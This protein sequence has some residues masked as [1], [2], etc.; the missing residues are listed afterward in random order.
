M[1][2]NSKTLQKLLISTLCAL[3][4]LI[5]LGLLSVPLSDYMPNVNSFFGII[6][7]FLPLSSLIIFAS[8]EILNRMKELS[9]MKDFFLSKKGFYRVLSIFV[10]LFIVSFS[11]Y[12]SVGFEI[13]LFYVIMIVCYFL[14]MMIYFR[15]GKYYELID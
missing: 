9:T 4:A 8:G 10:L 14:S 15:I 2:I 1:K 3:I 7:F 13:F 6:V 12:D 11:K 5:S